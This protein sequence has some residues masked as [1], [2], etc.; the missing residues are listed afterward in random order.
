MPTP[1]LR[2]AVP[3]TVPGDRLEAVDQ[4]R[5]ACRRWAS[6]A[7]VHLPYID[8]TFAFGFA[9]L[10]DA[11]RARNL[12]ERGTEELRSAQ[13]RVGEFPETVEKSAVEVRHFLV[14]IFRYRIE[15]VLTGRPHAGAL[16]GK[17]LIDWTELVRR[18]TV[19]IPSPSKL[20]VHAI[21]VY[22]MVSWVLEPSDP[23]DPYRTFT[24]WRPPLE[25]QLV[26]AEFLHDPVALT[27]Q[28]NDFVPR[29]ISAKQELKEINLLRDSLSLALRVGAEFAA[30]MLTLVRPVLERATNE[31]IV[32]GQSHSSVIWPLCRLLERGLYV[33]SCIGRADVVSEW[34]NLFEELV[35]R[36]PVEPRLKFVHMSGPQCLWSL[37]AFGLSEP[38]ERIT[39]HLRSLAPTSRSEDTPEA[40]ARIWSAQLV[41]AAACLALG[42]TE[43]AAPV[44][45]QVRRE[46]LGSLGAR[47]TSKDYTE[48]VWAFVFA[49]GQSAQAP[50]LE[51]LTD[52]FRE[53]PPEKVTNTWTTAAYFSRS[54]L[55]V[56]E[57]ALAAACQ[58]ALE[59]P[60]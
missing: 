42:Q 49:I 51:Q 41:V 11:D 2:P 54:H 38:I 56:T 13:V 12:L 27:E 3:G 10:G 8:L 14:A 7:P 15:Q 36:L 20:T 55:L 37:Q 50:G 23:V 4:L 58:M 35:E 45:T 48:L 25:Q 31:V 47:L 34:A 46:L 39:T 1:L 44:L 28:L 29:V 19:S 24:E 32:N 30:G 6:S 52:L 22:R 40:A 43:E 60:Q 33:A 9:L 53:L 57:G 21:N 5:T 26:D 16:S 17:V 18:A 59:L